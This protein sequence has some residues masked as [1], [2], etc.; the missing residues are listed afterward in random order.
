VSLTTAATASSPA[1]S[2]D[3]T[4]ADAVDANYNITHV[5]GTLT[6]GQSLTTGAIVSS[7]NPAV[8]GA[9]VTFTMTVSAVAPGAGTPSGS[10][11]FR[12][13]GSVAGS[14]TLSGG[15]ATFT[16]NNLAL[17]SHT[18]VA[19]YA[20]DS[21]FVG[22]TNTL[23][24]VQ[25]INTPPAAGDDTIERYA[26]GTVKVRLATLLGND[27][28]AD[29][30]TLTPTISPASANGG[31]ITVSGAWVFYTPAAGFTNADSFT[32]T[33]ADGRGG[34]DT[35]TVTVAIKVDNAP[36]QNLILTDLGGGQVRIDGH[37]IPGRTYRLQYSDSLTPA[38]WQILPGGSVTADS[39]G[40]FTF[41]DTP[42]GVRFYRTVY[43]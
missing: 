18:V 19:E 39:T 38:D 12:I 40:G 1:G 10:V 30:D 25:V 36:S 6:I 31:T 41:T 16:K 33:I 28:D 22:S 5:N 42:G 17:G 43:P 14:G 24:P 13:D 23:S 27:S 7:A 32:Y 37:G 11:D 3:I 35:A 21:N 20:G 4:A 9:D 29:S 15:V 34:S 2:Y 8:P 26:N